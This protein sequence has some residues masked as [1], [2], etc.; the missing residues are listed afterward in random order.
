V[1]VEGEAVR[2]T[3]EAALE[4][5]AEAWRGTWDG[6]RRYEVRG[7]AF[8]H[9]AG[10]AGRRRGDHAGAGPAGRP[11]DPR[12]PLLGRHGHH[13]G[14]VHPKVAGLVYVSALAPDAGETTAQQYEG[15]GRTPEFVIDVGEDG[16]GFLNRE[17][18][19]AGF[20][21]DAGDEDAAFLRD[22]QVPID[23]SV[24]AT[25]V[26]NAAWRDKPTWAVIATEDESFDQ[27]TLQHMAERAGAT[28]TNVSAGH[29][30]YLTRAGVVP[31][32]IDAAT[33]AAR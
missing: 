10:E 33:G 24:F 30:L 12:R 8:R 3:D 29:A 20:A 1:V 31:D 15:F 13:R 16:Y 2:V 5:L 6:R 17:K 21:H 7:G 14:R 26:K 19:T 4:R 11:H 23:M 22:S 18:F 28:I 9:E 27:A 25:P 32:V